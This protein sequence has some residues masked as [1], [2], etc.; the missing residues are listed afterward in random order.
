MAPWKPHGLLEEGKQKNPLNLTG[1]SW[2]AQNA[3]Y[4]QTAPGKTEIV[5]DTKIKQK[6]NQTKTPKHIYPNPPQI[7]PNNLQVGFA[8]F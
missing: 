2:A 1:R 6:P 5:N 8:L 7:N 3:E 4:M